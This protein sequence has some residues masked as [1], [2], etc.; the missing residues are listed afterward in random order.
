MRDLDENT[1]ISIVVP[2][3]NEE[4]A[5]CE[6]NRQLVAA[7]EKTGF[8]FELVYVEDGSTDATATLL[9]DLQRTDGRIRVVQLSRNFGHQ[10]AI[11]AGLEHA[12]GDAVVLIDADLQDP[13]DLIAE[14]VAHWIDGW[15]VVYGVRTERNGETLF[16]T[17]TAKLFYR[18]INA[19]SSTPVP[20]DAGDFRLMDRKVVNAVLSMPERDRFLRGMIAWVGFRQIPVYYQRS[21]RFAGTTKYPFKKMLHFAMDGVFSFSVVPLKLATY[22]GLISSFLALLGGLLAIMNRI[23]TNHWVIGWTSLFLAILFLGGVQL[24]CVGIIGEYVGRTYGEA[25][26][27]PLYFVQ[28]RLG[29]PDTSSREVHRQAT[30]NSRP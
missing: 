6:T 12:S 2:C 18:F 8:Q 3:F 9:T 24:T 28:E 10:V 22:L 15:D 1:C 19:L 16:K 25:K 5:I 29:F 17:Q 4:D 13:P 14:L 21:A 23:W 27:R 30:R 7:A 20:L 11:T 26:H